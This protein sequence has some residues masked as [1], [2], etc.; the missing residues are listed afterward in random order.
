MITAH[1]LTLFPEV[2]TPYMSHSLMGRALHNAHVSLNVVNPRDFTLNKHNKVDDSPYGGGVGMVMAC[3]PVVD[4]FRSL[5]ELSL[6]AT[7][8]VMT[9]PAGQPFS[10]T[11][12]KTWAKQSHVVFLCGHYEGFDARIPQLLAPHTVEEV[13]IGDYVLTG[14]ELPALVMLDALLRFVPGVVKE[15]DSVA[16]DSFENGLLD[17]P[18]Y[19]KPAEFQGLAVPEV[20][21]QGNHA[22]IAQWRREQSLQKTLLVRPDLLESVDLTKSDRRFLASLGWTPLTHKHL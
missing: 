7:T 20:L 2:I 18:H 8:V 21:R 14:G 15:A 17:Y 4:A 19:T 1:V 16:E 6:E 10:N 5:G 11:L 22:H 13:S 12:A 9:S 3:Q